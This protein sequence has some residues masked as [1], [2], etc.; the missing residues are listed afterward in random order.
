MPSTKND[1]PP[2]TAQPLGDA[3]TPLE[4]QIRQCFGSVVWAHKTQEKEADACN[5]ALRRFKLGQIAVSAVTTSGALAVIVANNNIWAKVITVVFSMISLFISAYMKGFDPGGAA[6]KHRSTAANLW[7]I[8][9]SYL[10]LL[11]DLRTK[12]ITEA[13]TRKRRDKLQKELATIYKEAPQTT[14]SAYSNAS[15]ALK[16][17]EEYTFKDSEIDA[18]LPPALRKSRS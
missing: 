12:T 7:A 9:E 6:Q 15:D 4:E 11:T 14:P 10:S 18:F 17:R 5:A 2:R 13:D 3:V 8:R 16:N 1:A